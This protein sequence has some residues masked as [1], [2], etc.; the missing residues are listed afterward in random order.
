MTDRVTN[1]MA[2]VQNVYNA[3]G[4]SLKMGIHKN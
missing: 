2:R 3:N 1:I 4:H